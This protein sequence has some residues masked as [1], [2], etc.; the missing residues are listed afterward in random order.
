M[1]TELTADSIPDC[2]HFPGIRQLKE[3]ANNATI[4]TDDI[5]QCVSL[6]DLE[7]CLACSA[8]GRPRKQRLARTAIVKGMWP[9]RNDIADDVRFRT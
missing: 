1:Q 6:H 3:P 2:N 4:R 8:S 5:V 7:P 9:D